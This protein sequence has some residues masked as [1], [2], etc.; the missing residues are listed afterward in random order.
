MNH[1]DHRMLLVPQGGAV[2]LS[3]YDPADTCGF[4]DHAAAQEKL[5]SDIMRLRELQDVFYAARAYAL[6]VI[7]QAMDAAGK[8]GAIKH[9]MTGV[10]PQG[11]QVTS[12]RA[13]SSD[14]LEHDYLWRHVRALPERGQI[15]IFNRSHYEEVLAVRVH[16][17]LLAQQRLPTGAQPVHLWRERFEDINAFERHLVRNGTLVVKFFLHVS[18]AEQR[19]RLLARID[20]PEKNWK[21]SLRDLEERA[22]WSAYM[23][24]YESALAHT[25]TAWAPWYVVPADHKWLTRV[26][27]ADVLVAQLSALGLRYPPVDDAQ[28]KVLRQARAQ[29][30]GACTD[31]KP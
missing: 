12:F 31:R 19:R 2:R 1:L 28:R 14:E 18:E 7:F 13:P 22:S 3:D 5:E 8:D 6:L 17:E 9:V 15:G 20:T 21:F 16:P 24:T 27:V 23:Q 26:V 30:A 11:V 29:L 25:S 10:N 4:K